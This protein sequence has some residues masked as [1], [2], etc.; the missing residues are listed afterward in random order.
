MRGTS[1]KL[2]KLVDA[3]ERHHR[4]VLGNVPC[5]GADDALRELVTHLG[6]AMR[7]LTWLISLLVC[8]N[9]FAAEI[10]IVPIENTCPRII[11]KITGEI[12]TGDTKKFT[13]ALERAQATWSEHC[14]RAIN[15]K[16][17]MLGSDGGD[18]EEALKLGR[19]LRRLEF[20]TAVDFGG[21]C[22]SACVVVFA[23]GIERTAFPEQLGVHRPYF[24][25]LDA[26]LSAGSI[27]MMREK[28]IASLR[29]YFDEMDIDSSLVDLML[30]IPPESM[31]IL[32]Q[33]ESDRYRLIGEDANYEERRIAFMAKVL[34]ITSTEYRKRVELSNTQCSYLLSEKKLLEWT[35]C[36][37]GVIF[38]ISAA[39]YRRRTQEAESLC[40]KEG[41]RAT[42]CTYDILTSRR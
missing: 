26:T 22:H 8:A 13:D 17:V 28:N 42:S 3:R 9:V 4:F 16:G 14:N 33:T 2:V 15:F 38:Q 25:R 39:E 37:G 29:R 1:K 24:Q 21:N 11:V 34:K 12:A 27:K 41:S 36:K 20:N 30:S 35:E 6:V 7:S 31:H 19:L 18:I 5:I 32:T 23:A 10:S 40:P